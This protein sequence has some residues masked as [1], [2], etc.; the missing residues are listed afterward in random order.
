MSFRK[1]FIELREKFEIE[2]KK[3]EQEN[4]RT[5]ESSFRIG[6]KIQVIHKP[7]SF[8]NIPSHNDTGYLQAVEKEHIIL[9]R[10]DIKGK[11][12]FPQ[13]I[14]FKDIKEIISVE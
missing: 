10:Q 8:G 14:F 9:S 6:E 1:K 5:I 11:E 4:K 2:H 3:L 13:N 7:I 12:G